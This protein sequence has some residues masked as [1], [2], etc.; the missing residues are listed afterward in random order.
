MAEQ[1]HEVAKYCIIDALSCQW[2]MIK[3]N[4]INKY[5]EVAS[6]AFLSLFDAHYFVG[7]MKVCNLLSASVWQIG[8]LTSMILSQQTETGK[9]PEAYVFPPVKGLENRRPVTGLD[10]ASLYLS[11]IMTY[12]LSPDK[13]ILSQKHAVSVEKSDKRLHKIEFLFNNNPQRAWSVWHNNIPEEKVISSMGKGLSLSEAIEQVLANAEKEKHSGLANNLYHFI[14]KEKHEF[15]AEYNSLYSKS[16]FFLRELAG[17]VTSAGLRNIKLVTDFVKIE[18]V[19]RGKSSLFRKVG[20][21]IMDESMKVNNLRTLHQI[22]EDV[23]RETVKDIFQTDLN[24]IIK[25]AVWKSDKDN[26]SVQRF[27]LR[28]RDRHTREVADT[29]RFIKKGLTPEPYLH[30]IPESGERFEYVVVKNNS[31]ERVGGQNGIPRSGK[32]YQPSSKIVLKAL[33]KL[34]DGNKADDD[35][36]DV[37]EDEVDEDEMDEDE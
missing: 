26:K 5:R 30:Q 16:P 19:K 22:I 15:I 2:L 32:T 3:H 17:G 23:L 20:R 25:T 34:K 11:L 29:K 35:E 1:M 33:K 31:S 8:I 13:I 14:H 18:I 9:F 21:H 10:F 4:A 28:M 6:V 12:N 36:D 7:G 27:I 24:E 37:D